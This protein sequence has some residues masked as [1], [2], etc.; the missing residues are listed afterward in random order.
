M[1][2]ERELTQL[3]LHH[4]KKTPCSQDF[5]KFQILILQNLQIFKKTC[6]SKKINREIFFES[7]KIV[8]YT[9][10]N[11]YLQRA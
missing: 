6:R 3:C 11:Y 2:S 9:F 5:A 8:N 1:R 10:L 4:V 7:N